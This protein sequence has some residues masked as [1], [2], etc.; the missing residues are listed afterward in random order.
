MMAV[1]TF[2]CRW[3][4]GTHW[5]LPSQLRE[6]PMKAKPAKPY[7]HVTWK[8]HVRQVEFW[9]CPCLFWR[10]ESQGGSP[11]TSTHRTILLTMEVSRIEN[12]K[13]NLCNQQYILRHC[14]IVVFLFQQSKLQYLITV[15]EWYSTMF[16][17][18]NQAVQWFECIPGTHTRKNMFEIWHHPKKVRCFKHPIAHYTTP[19]GSIPKLGV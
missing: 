5:L 1:H 15:P 9:I 7:P 12:P 11:I 4:L 19:W 13:K 18:T 14:I 8:K 6:K 2:F 3:S 16:E 10:N 17:D